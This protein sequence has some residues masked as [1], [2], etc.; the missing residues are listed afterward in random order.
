[1]KKINCV[2]A[3]LVGS[4]LLFSCGENNPMKKIKEAK[5]GMGAVSELVSAGSGAMKDVKNLSEVDA[6]SQQDFEKW[7]PGTS[8]RGLER[9]EM[10]LGN[11]S[12]A[13]IH[14]VYGSAN[15][16]KRLDIVVVDGADP[17][18]TMLI[19]MTNMFLNSDLAKKKIN[20]DPNDGNIVDK[21]GV[22]AKE[23]YSGGDNVIETVVNGRFYVKL[24]GS[25]MTMDEVWDV[26]KALK[27]DKL[28]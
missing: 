17:V 23:Y 6:W 2:L 21:H 15:H 27:T 26:F 18:G 16:G 13:S 25:D 7:A 9:T 22:T 8:F 14:I 11:H 4:A 10:T 12:E 19:S 1:M 24:A 20:E 28:K 3:G 5:D